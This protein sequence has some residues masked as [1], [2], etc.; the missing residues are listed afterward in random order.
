[1]AANNNPKQG[2]GRS[3]AQAAGGAHVKSPGSEGGGAKL[4]SAKTSNTRMTPV[5]PV[6]PEVK[7]RN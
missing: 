2:S 7:V 3:N 6:D 1:M 5:K 4:G